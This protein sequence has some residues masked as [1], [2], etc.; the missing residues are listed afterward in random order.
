MKK[1]EHGTSKELI[2]PEHNMNTLMTHVYD[3]NTELTQAEHYVNTAITQHRHGMST[4]LTQRRNQRD[5]T[6][7]KY[8]PKRLFSRCSH[9]DLFWNRYSF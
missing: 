3:K 5:P 8:P 4:A 7:R 2:L 1:R 9:R 6:H